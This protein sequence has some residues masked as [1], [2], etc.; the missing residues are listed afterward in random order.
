MF[1]ACGITLFTVGLWLKLTDN[2][3][4][5]IQ[6]IIDVN[7]SPLLDVAIIILICVGGVTLLMGFLGCW[8]ACS[9]SSIMLCLVSIDL[10]GQTG[11]V[12]SSKKYL[13]HQTR[14]TFTKPISN[15]ILTIVMQYG[16]NQPT[17]PEFIFSKR[18]DLK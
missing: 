9:E 16:D 7:D 8:G 12:I 11:L 4:K 18:W 15:P 2:T 17:F 1:Q 13:P 6:L 3:G 14:I 10:S 5:Y